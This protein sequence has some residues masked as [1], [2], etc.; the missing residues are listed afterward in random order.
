M[1]QL[2]TKHYPC[3]RERSVCW[4]VLDGKIL[5]VLMQCSAQ[6]L[7]IKCG[8]EAVNDTIAMCKHHAKTKPPQL[9]LKSDKIHFLE[10][11]IS[12]IHILVVIKINQLSEYAY[13]QIIKFNMCIYNAL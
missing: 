13:V 12:Y 11:S 6:Y 9:I 10:N 7:N 4:T 5:S 3:G 1:V 8:N 2:R